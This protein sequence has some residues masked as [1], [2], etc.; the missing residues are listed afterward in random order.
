MYNTEIPNTTELPTS[1][2]LVRST[3]I[4]ATVA[5]ALLITT[6]LPAEYGI[7][8]TGAGRFL[9]LTTMGEI[10][11]SLTEEAAMDTAAQTETPAP[12]LP[13]VQ[14]A[15]A[16]PVSTPATAEQ[17][18]APPVAEPQQP[19][20]PVASDKKVFTLKPGEAAEIKLGMKEGA[21]VSFDWRVKGGAVNFD[22]HGDAP[23]L[24]YYGYNK[25]RKVMG[26]SGT[27]TAAFDGKHGWFWRNRSG[28]DATIT[29]T[30]QGDYQL[31][32][33]VM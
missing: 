3:L 8:P 12:S 25:G 14:A 29:L 26:D 19:A 4:A 2:Q 7:D 20:R 15:S 6:V 32:K 1:K 30:T 18:V 16:A 23:G 22:T 28:N 17:T 24:D 33:R 31:I 21:V 9:G 13:L 10:K 11:T 27:L 5:A